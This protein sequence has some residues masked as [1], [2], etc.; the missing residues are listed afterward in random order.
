MSFMCHIHNYTE[1]NEEWNVFSLF[2][3]ADI[4]V[5]GEQLGFA[6]LL[7]GLTS[8]MDTSCQSWDLNPQPWVTS[9]F[10]S[11]ALSIKPRLLAIWKW[12]WLT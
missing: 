8:V 11:N 4:A 2:N 12:D 5:P 6:A 1:Y 9:C 10:K 7:K 3:P